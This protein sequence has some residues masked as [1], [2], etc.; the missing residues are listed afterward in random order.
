[1][2]VSI[3]IVSLDPNSRVYQQIDIESSSDEAGDLDTDDVTWED[4]FP[5]EDTDDDPNS[6]SNVGS[7]A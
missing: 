1:M 2:T 7:T 3:P 5:E 6:T 4:L